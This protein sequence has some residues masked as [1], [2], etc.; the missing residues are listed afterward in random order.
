VEASVKTVDFSEKMDK[1]IKDLA[2]SQKKTWE[3][4]IQAFPALA[5]TPAD[6]GATRHDPA[7]ASAARAAEASAWPSATLLAEGISAGT[8]AVVGMFELSASAWESAAKGP[9]SESGFAE[10][11]LES[12]DKLQEMFRIP[13]IGSTQNLF[14][15]WT[16]SLEEFQKLQSAELQKL[17]GPWFEA[18]NE[19]GRKVDGASDGTDSALGRFS[20]LYWNTF[21]QTIGRM[22]ES[23]SVGHTREFDERFLRSSSAW[24]EF[25]SATFDY[26]V[27][28]GDAWRKALVEFSGEIASLAG[29]GKTITSLRELLTLWTEVADRVM[30]ETFRNER[31]A[32]AQGRLLNAA[33]AYRLEEQK[34]V[35]A[36]LKMGHLPTRT[37]MDALA[38]EMVEL[39]R[40]LRA[41]TKKF[42]QAGSA[43]QPVPKPPA[44]AKPAAAKPAAA[45]PA[46]PK[47]PPAKAKPANK[48]VEQAQDRT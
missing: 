22:L 16:L 41:V 39:R 24:F 14:Q 1:I 6:V 42:D 34:A 11:V 4:W 28:L 25:R 23:P 18:L 37:E 17:S 35:E 47:S 21:E 30:I 27:V 13:S 38:R 15:L 45:K 19:G 46:A 3:G 43:D 9:G 12:V 2:E 20:D 36:L 31:Y 26:L 8:R 5:S 32:R 29:R 44:A 10:A 48:G 40:Q 7:E 33:M